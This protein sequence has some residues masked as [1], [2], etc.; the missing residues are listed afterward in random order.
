LRYGLRPVASHSTDPTVAELVRALALAPHPEGGFYRETYRSPLRLSTPRGERAALTAIHFLL[1]A[2]ALSLFHRVAA[3]EVWA[4]AGGGELELHLVSPAG[5]HEVVLLGGAAGT[6]RTHAV[7]P[8]GHWQA[9][10]PSGGR[11]VLTTCV[12]APGF[13]FADFELATRGEL[14]RLF[15]AL[16]EAVLA[17]AAPGD[18]H[19]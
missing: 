13:E 2:G 15:P 8:A 16:P 6:A 18:P 19:A 7:V 10:R 17:L 3:E 4:H 12:V 9:A 1:P 14:A 5:R 11:Y